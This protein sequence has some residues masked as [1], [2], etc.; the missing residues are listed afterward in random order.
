M[1][2]SCLCDFARESVF[3]LEP[4]SRAVNT[5]SDFGK[6]CIGNGQLGEDPSHGDKKEK[7][8]EVIPTPVIICLH[9]SP[10]LTL[11]GCLKDAD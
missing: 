11:P 2:I 8:P 10:L 9:I 6:G 3:P 1:W 7:M 5:M 4:C